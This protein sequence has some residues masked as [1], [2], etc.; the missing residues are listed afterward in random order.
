MQ[1]LEAF[2]I[3]PDFPGELSCQ[4][5]LLPAKLSMYSASEMPERS[6]RLRNTLGL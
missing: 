5:A 2:R 6:R 4:S 3:T 1:K